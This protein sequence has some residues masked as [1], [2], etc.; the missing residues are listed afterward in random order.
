MMP[1]ETSRNIVTMCEL[2]YSGILLGIVLKLIM[3]DFQPI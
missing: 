3:L 1:K 2:I